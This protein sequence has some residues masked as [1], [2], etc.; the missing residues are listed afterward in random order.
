MHCL[1]EYNN[2]A[3]YKTCDDE[4]GGVFVYIGKVKGRFT[5][6]STVVCHLKKRRYEGGE[7]AFM[8]I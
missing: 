8:F 5:S 6:S 1:I 7:C 4:G 3:L 2:V